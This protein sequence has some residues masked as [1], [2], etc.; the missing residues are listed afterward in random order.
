MAWVAA[1]YLMA[2]LGVM[3]FC[4]VGMICAINGIA[5]TIFFG[6][7]I[8]V[9]IF[10]VIKM[11]QFWWQLNC[12]LVEAGWLRSFGPVL[13]ESASAWVVIQLLATIVTVSVVALLWCTFRIYRREMALFDARRE[14]KLQ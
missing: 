5:V 1:F 8:A 13:G 9:S 3:L 4:S 7:A 10:G 6:V 11:T 12:Y 2:L 14:K